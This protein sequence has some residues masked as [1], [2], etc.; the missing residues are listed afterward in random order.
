[1]KKTSKRVKHV[2]NY[3]ILCTLI[4][5][6]MLNTAMVYATDVKKTSTNRDLGY[7][8][9]WDYE[10][11]VPIIVT[12]NNDIVRYDYTYDTNGYRKS[13]DVDGITTFFEYDNEGYLISEYNDRYR[14]K[15]LYKETQ[16][17][18]IVDACSINGVNYKFLK[19]ESM[20][21]TGLI[22]ENDNVCVMYEY[23]S[24]YLLNGVYEI[25]NGERYDK[26]D[27]VNF[28]GNFVHLLLNGQYYDEETKLYYYFRRYF[29]SATGQFVMAPNN[30]EL[31]V[32]DEETK[33]QEIP[34]LIY[35]MKQ[36]PYKIS[37]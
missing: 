14:V 16:N 18:K 10:Y 36:L 2:K 27:E 33:K 26:K 15:Y 31:S 20:N 8:L 28:Y 25:I 24:E 19:D 13:K 11:E 4:F 3:M 1:M 5:S 35:M 37:Y 34:I 12:I 29:N 22:D 23:D 7:Y 30:S 17:G 21:I 9:E 32:E 6:M